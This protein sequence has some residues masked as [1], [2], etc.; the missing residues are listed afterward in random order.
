M[1]SKAGIS[2]TKPQAPL[3]K[4]LLIGAIALLVIAGMFVVVFNLPVVT[5]YVPA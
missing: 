1:R 5:G 4:A 2:G 3:W